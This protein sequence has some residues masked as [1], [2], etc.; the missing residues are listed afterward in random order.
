MREYKEVCLQL[1]RNIAT[2]ETLE[3]YTIAVNKLK[4]HEI[5]SFPK[6]SRFRDWV[7]KTWLQL[8][9][10]SYLATCQPNK[11]CASNARHF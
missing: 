8:Y 2:S 4:E 11:A 10:V 1:L 7:D 3:E 6:A 9:Q 5:W